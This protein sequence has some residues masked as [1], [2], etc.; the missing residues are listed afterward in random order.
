[1][2]R[3]PAQLLLV[4]AA[5]LVPQIVM[6]QEASR[7]P[8]VGPPPHVTAAWDPDLALDPK[9]IP[10][11]ST[12]VTLA[13]PNVT[14]H[15]ALRALI[16][17]AKLRLT[18]SGTLLPADRK[19]TIDARNVA[20]GAVLTDVLKGSGLDVFADRDGALA[21]V[22]CPHEGRTGLASQQQRGTVVGVVTDRSTGQPLGGATVWVESTARPV[23]ADMGGHYRIG[24]LRVGRHT[25]KARYI[26]YEADSVMVQV[27]FPAVTADV[28]LARSEQMLAEVVT[29]GTF[30][31]RN[32]REL[33]TPITVITA[34]AIAQQRPQA[35]VDLIRQAVPTAVGFERPSGSSSQTFFSVRGVSS[36]SGSSPLKILLDGIEV[37]SFTLSPVDPKSIERIE[38]V[39]GPQ[40]GTIFGADAAGGVIQIFT[41]RGDSGL[42]S[43]QVTVEAGLGVLQTPYAGHRGVLRQE[44]TGAVQG[45]VQGIT[46]HLGGGYTH[47][48]DFVPTGDPSRQSIPSLYGG[49][50]FRRGFVTVDVSGR[51]YRNRIPATLNPDI[52]RSGFTPLSQPLYEMNDQTNE[53]LGARV[54]VTPVSWLRHQT[55]VGIDRQALS[56]FQTR[57]RFTIPSDTLLALRSNRSRKL[58]FSSNATALLAPFRPIGG[59]LTVGL[60]HYE[61]WADNFSTTN[62]LNTDGVIVTSPPGSFERSRSRTRNTGYFAQGQV[63]LRQELF[64]TAALRAEQSTTFGVD[65]RTPWLP[66]VGLSFIAL[67]GRP[68]LKV[69]GSWGRGI[70]AP[71]P[72]QAFGVANAFQEYLPNPQ[73]GP[74]EQEGWDAGIDLIFGSTASFSV[75]GFDQRARN[76]I[77]LAEVA[78]DPIQTYQFRNIGRVTNKGVEL[79]A[80]LSTGNLTLR[81]HYGYVSS[82]I[83]AM[84]TLSA[85]EI[86]VGDRPNGVPAHTGAATISF[87]P[88]A[89]TTVS[90][91]LTYIG[92]LRSG[93]ALGFFRCIGGTGPCPP[94]SEFSVEYPSLTKINVVCTQRMS[95]D[96]EGYLAVDNLTNN[97]SYEGDN[98]N[99]VT[100][101]L[102]MAGLKATF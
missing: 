58:S 2:S 31:P 76:L 67:A 94:G 84:A 4:M 29:T 63:R 90:T 8:P 30:V 64:L 21:L 35:L 11:L 14:L 65:S 25:V 62:A 54:L 60:D 18:Y 66:S 79:E 50:Q 41:K 5:A 80:S 27:S 26:G 38:V 86:D 57:R 70:R 55:V 95:Q 100:G 77:M 96:L 3:H 32:V 9:R 19:V 10:A 20:A 88:R 23:T 22:R 102:T 49:L 83:A 74:E 72:G 46:Y 37:T 93:D 39:R 56:A 42:V 98:I 89:G 82:R 69:R 78:T 40:A 61:L 73:L 16:G 15:R 52:L 6:G 71:S 12:Y 47:L 53:A 48:D 13:L 91:T 51:H 85:G 68:I 45:G 43:P 97:E 92:R 7:T 87:A 1:V 75:T 28:A 24:D 81:A 33:A 34:E 99:P 36:L 59:S 101:R 44:Y 17:A